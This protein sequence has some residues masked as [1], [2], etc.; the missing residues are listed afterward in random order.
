[1]SRAFTLERTEDV[2]GISGTGTV[3]DGVEFP[4][5]FAVIRWRGDRRS[6]VL[7]E[8]VDQL[9]EVHG[10]DGRTTVVWEDDAVERSA[11]LAARYVTDLPTVEPLDRETTAHDRSRWVIAGGYDFR[12]VT[13]RGMLRELEERIRAAVA[14]AEYARAELGQIEAQHQQRLAAWA[15]QPLADRPQA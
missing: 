1:M 14:V 10:H 9:L 15:R 13:N 7:W 12:R 2:S 11:A 8:N 3:A 5:G 6:T 4:D